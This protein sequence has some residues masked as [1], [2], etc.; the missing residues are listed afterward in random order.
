MNNKKYLKIIL[1]T[2]CLMILNSINKS[3]SE[4]L[5]APNKNP[6]DFYNTISNIELQ[7]YGKDYE[8]DNPVKRIERLEK[9]FYGT[10]LNGSIDK[11]LS[12]LVNT[13][14]LNKNHTQNMKDLVML[15][16]M[17][18]KYLGTSYP[19][20]SFDIRVA[21][22][23]KTVFGKNFI[24]D[25]NLRFQNLS[26]KIPLTFTGVMLT[27]NSNQKVS[28]NSRKNPKESSEIYSPINTVENSNNN[29]YFDNI[30]K[31]K[32]NSVIRWNDTP[33]YIYIYQNP[34]AVNDIYH[35]EKAVEIWSEY[36]P[37]VETNDISSAQIIVDWK[38]S[39][40]PITQPEPNLYGNK[41]IYQVTVSCGHYIKEAYFQS[42]ILHELGHAIGIWGH[43][44]NPE[45]I[46]YN[47]NEINSDLKQEETKNEN[48]NSI[49][50]APSSPSQRDI[51]TLKEIYKSPSS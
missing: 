26:K 21:R 32:G 11:R 8:N 10:N 4:I 20:D 43:S 27:D 33:V 5:Y 6:A 19:N 51:N 18:T 46:M 13:T 49:Q 31:Y 42:F 35:I 2:L 23:E 1:F 15:D 22:L 47:F 34:Q 16:L 14:K 41:I 24:G 39:I 29:N 7:A 25:T 3:F 37:I 48:S 28:L 50:N 36:I 17:E 30:K 9:T 38:N 45:D 12:N 40:Y 44:S